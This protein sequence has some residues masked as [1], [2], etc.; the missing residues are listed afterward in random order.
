M[1]KAT[2]TVK[3]YGRATRDGYAEV[4]SA[5]QYEK[6]VIQRTNDF[7]EDEIDFYDW[8][9]ETY[10][11]SE[12]WDMSDDEKQRVKEEEYNEK[13]IQWALDDMENEYKEFEVTIDIDSISLT[14]ITNTTMERG[15]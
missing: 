1:A 14:S 7:Y 13:C 8:L 5:E 15:E 11:V 10:S 4:I 6:E 2:T 12:V 3:V 9:E